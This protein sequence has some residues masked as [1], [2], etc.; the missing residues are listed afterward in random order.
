M[1]VPGGDQRDWEFATTMDLPIIRTTEPPADFVSSGGEAYAG[2]GATINSPGPGIESALDIN[3][4]GVAD[5]KAATV[6]HLEEIGHG[7]GTVNFRLRDWLLS[8]Q[9]YWGA[10]IPVIHC[11]S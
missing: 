2:E 6:A 3:G 4:L 9:R 5:A 8:R 7:T 1:G 10:P 11:P